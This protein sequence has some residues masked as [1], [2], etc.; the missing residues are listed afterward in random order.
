[1][2]PDV[3]NTATAY[4]C[5]KVSLTPSFV[6]QTKIQVSQLGVTREQLKK[7]KSLIRTTRNPGAQVRGLLACT[8]KYDQGF[9]VIP[10]K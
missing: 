6:P 7:F 3:E 4:K 5:K 2:A 10:V 9:L 1:M 8:K